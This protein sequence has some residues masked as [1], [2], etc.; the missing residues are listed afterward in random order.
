MNGILGANANYRSKTTAGFGGSNL[1]DI[2][3]YWLVDLRAGI[4]FKDGKYS[5]Q[6]FGRNITNQYYWTNVARSLDNVRRYAGAPATYGIQFS[7]KY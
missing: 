3:A 1:L 2:D 4:D 5:V 6:I 7:A